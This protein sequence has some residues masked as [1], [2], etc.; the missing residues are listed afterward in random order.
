ML[1]PERWK[2]VGEIFSAAMETPL[3]GR[4]AFV[5]EFPADPLVKAEVLRLLSLT[6]GAED[7]L[8]R[9]A[10]RAA[11]STHS[12]PTRLLAPAELIGDRFRIVRL[13]GRGGMAEVYE[14]ED[15][16]LGDRVA[17]KVMHTSGDVTNIAARLR[18][19]V[20]LARRITHPGVCRVHDVAF[21]K[22]SDG[23]DLVLLTMELLEGETLWERLQR[24]PVPREEALQIAHQLAEAL[25]AAH[26]Q[27]I[28]HRDLKP[29]NVIL[30]RRAGGPIRAVLTDFGLA[31]ALEAERGPDVTRAGTIVGTPEYMAPEQLKGEEATIQSDLYGFGLILYELAIGKRYPVTA[32]WRSTL[33][34][35]APEIP[36]SAGIDQKWRYVLQRVLH[37]DPRQRFSSAGEMVRALG[38]KRNRRLRLDMSRRAAASAVGVLVV[39]LSAAALRFYW[40]VPSALAPASLVVLTPIANAT[41]DEDLVGATQVLQ[42]QLAQSP[43]FE[44]VAADRVRAVVQ[45]MGRPADGPLDVETAREVALREGAGAVIYWTLSKLG[46]EYLLSVRLEKVGSRPTLVKAD[47]SQTFRAPD[48]ALLFGSFREAALWVRELVGESAADL[49]DQDR[50]PSDTT[51]TSWDALRLY[52]RA[53]ARHAAGRLDEAV[54]LLEQALRHDPTFATAQMRLAD[55]LISL[56]RDAEGYEAWRNAIRLLEEQQLT[57]RESLRVKGQY[58]EDTGDLAGAEK[59]YR[60]YALHYPNDYHANFFLGSVL[61]DVGRTADSVSSLQRASQIR[62]EMLAAPVHLATA[63]LE[64]GQTQEAAVVIGQLRQR[65]HGAWAQWLEALAL[66]A[67]RRIDAALDA[68]EPLTK[69]ADSRWRSRAFTLRAS[70][71]AEA[72]RL[73]EAQAS[74]QEGLAIDAAEGLQE[75][76]TDKWLH[77]ADLYRRSSNVPAAADAI[78]RGVGAAVSPKQLMVAISIL[79]RA[80]R[81]QEAEDLLRRFDG[82]VDV[83]RVRAARLRA[84]AEILLARDDPAAALTKLEAAGETPRR[85][86]R[87]PLVRALIATK[88]FERA[89]RVL[90]ELVTRP[91]LHYSSPEPEF[92]AMWTDAV[93]EYATQLQRSDPAAAAQY[94]DLY[95]QLHSAADTDANHR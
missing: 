89:V 9:P 84:E 90:G 85:E 71:L 69:D 78:A 70:W 17:L 39:A 7:F 92:P 87:Q 63:F 37:S 67:A 12:D 88:Q 77:L 44:L 86:S 62:P 56:K 51:T 8:E 15:A 49:G 1:T 30:V 18:R 81:L 54:L 58:L 13:L 4:R 66:F 64:L 26:A 24:G 45:Q 23:T 74:L 5:E 19:E 10:G 3:P 41:G 42:S 61:H 80:G 83:P 35:G 91:T 2:E 95:R 34:G 76:Q 46:P 28:L 38:G 11:P 55:V 52:A 73:R 29:G 65:G 50:P 36:E 82:Q 93:L 59:A 57:S 14:A 75:R 16:V 33:D 68:L 79:A 94:R 72:G 47:W 6:D 21:Q 25:D 40:Q 48:K 32:A 22:R 31:R 20:Q 27:R 60:A 43:H 53:E